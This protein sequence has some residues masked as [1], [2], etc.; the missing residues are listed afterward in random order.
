LALKNKQ[1]FSDADTFCWTSAKSSR[2]QSW[3]QAENMLT[4]TWQCSKATPEISGIMHR[5]DF[6]EAYIGEDGHRQLTKVPQSE[7]WLKPAKDSVSEAFVGKPEGAFAVIWVRPEM[8][9]VGRFT[10]G[11]VGSP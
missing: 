5:A 10:A 1:K 4:E 2:R 9:N 7:L 8:A 6:A 3:H 11:R